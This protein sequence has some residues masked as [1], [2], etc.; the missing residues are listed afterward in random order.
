MVTIS[1][2]I[3]A[4]NEENTIANAIMGL[5]RQNV[6]P[7]EIIV[8]NDG[9]TDST[10]Q[11]V[12]KIRQ[13]REEWGKIIRM[14]S[15][16]KGHGA[17]F[18]R[19]RGAES[20]SGDILFFLDSDVEVLDME[21]VKKI[22]N[23]FEKKKVDAL[24]FEGG[25]RHRTLLQKAYFVR[26]RI[27][28][29]YDKIFG[30]FHPFINCIRKEIFFK[31]GKFNEKLFYY[32]DEEFYGKIASKYKIGKLKTN[33]VH[34]DP[35]SFDEVKRQSSWVGRGATTYGMLSKKPL[36][37]L[38]PLYPAFWCA[39]F[40]LIVLFLVFGGMILQVAVSLFTL[41]LFLQIPLGII[42]SSA[43]V[44]VIFYVFI[45]SPIRSF[46]TIKS[47]FENTLKSI[48]GISRKKR[49]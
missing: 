4:H 30:Y 20:A 11:I 5:L 37:L 46:F 6:L 49:R 23:E 33:T 12:E 32:E 43:F 38:Y 48:S 45:L 18:A 22:K 13:D 41:L 9:S 36:Y 2:V 44:P 3:P 10:A 35:N 1:V 21:L 28:H 19:N 7:E 27:K 26:A 17:A 42:L 8:V 14:I 47:F 31:E 24:Y 39:F 40:L 16:D 34:E 29:F 25:G 15:F